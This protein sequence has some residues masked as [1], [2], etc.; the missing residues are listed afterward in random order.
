MMKRGRGNV[1]P[2]LN[3]LTMLACGG[4]GDKTPCVCPQ[5]VKKLH[6]STSFIP[7]GKK[8]GGKQSG[9]GN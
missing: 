1:G 6:T 2:I 9:F 5:H 8:L 7:K 3:H 4:H